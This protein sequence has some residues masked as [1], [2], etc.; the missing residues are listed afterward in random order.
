MAVVAAV[1]GVPERAIHQYSGAVASTS[2]AIPLLPPTARA[3]TAV[4]ATP[5]AAEMAEGHR[6]A[7]ADG[8]PLKRYVPAC[9]Q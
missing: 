4:T 5:R 8:P 6:A 3:K 2:A 9:S 1:S 7:A